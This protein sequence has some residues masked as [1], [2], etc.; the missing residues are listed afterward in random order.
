MESF[1]SAVKRIKGDSPKIIKQH[2]D[3]LFDECRDLVIDDIRQMESPQIPSYIGNDLYNAFAEELNKRA[4]AVPSINHEL[5]EE[6]AKRSDNLMKIIQNFGKEVSSLKA[7]ADK[8]LQISRGHG[9]EVRDVL[10]QIE[11]HFCYD[12]VI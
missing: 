5:L 8:I 7:N 6:I 12:C 9:G 11:W 1:I 4:D 10:Q 2:I 3:A